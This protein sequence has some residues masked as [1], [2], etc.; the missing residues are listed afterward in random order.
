MKSAYAFRR[1]NDYFTKISTLRN[2]GIDTCELEPDHISVTFYQDI[3]F[4]T[5]KEI[6]DS[7]LQNYVDYTIDNLNGDLTLT[8]FDLNFEDD[9]IIYASIT[10][11]HPGISNDYSIL[12]FDTTIKLNELEKYYDAFNQ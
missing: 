9:T 7:I 5:I 1:L 4:D 8:T 11:C 2:S 3:G 12:S 6:I 10:H